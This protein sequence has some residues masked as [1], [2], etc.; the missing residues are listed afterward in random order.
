MRFKN[1]KN[2]HRFHAFESKFMI[3]R[4]SLIQIR[5]RNFN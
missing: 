2:G 3:K 4:F 1:H 5:D